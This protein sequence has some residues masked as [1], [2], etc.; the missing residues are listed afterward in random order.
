M[1]A[2]GTAQPPSLRGASATKQSRAACRPG[3]LRGACHRAGHSG[4]T[5]WLATTRNLSRHPEVRAAKPRASKDARPGPSPFEGDRIF[6]Q[7]SIN[8]DFIGPFYILPVTNI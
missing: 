2:P 6:S 5:R 8:L 7:N 3:L 4:P 1:N